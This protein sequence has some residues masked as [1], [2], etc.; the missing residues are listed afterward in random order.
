M[1]IS[2]APSVWHVENSLGLQK[3]MIV[4]NFYT[5]FLVNGKLVVL[6]ELNMSCKGNSLNLNLIFPFLKI[7]S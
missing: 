6:N 1:P 3:K 7:L 5:R 4:L 2:T